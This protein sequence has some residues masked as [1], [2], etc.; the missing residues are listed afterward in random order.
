MAGRFSADVIFFLDS[1]GSMKPCFKALRDNIQSFVGPLDGG[2]QGSWDLRLDFLSHRAGEQGRCGIHDFGTV[3]LED[4]NRIIKSLYGQQEESK[5]FFTSEVD[6]F[7]RSLMNLKAFGDEANFVALDTCLDFPWRESST[8]HRVV[9]LLTDEPLET[10]VCVEQ[11]KELI[12]ALIEKLHALS[13]KLFLVGPESWAYDHLCAADRSEYVVVDEG[14]AGLT[15]VDL[16]RVLEA[17]AKS[18]SVSILQV[19]A[20]ANPVKRGLFDQ[21]SWTEV[22]GNL[23]EK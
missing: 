6:S 13:V 11:Q 18:I 22:R 4:A 1:S 20:G 21:A 16:G 8:C 12:N 5:S 9:I 3:H 23:R 10:G 19:P 7:R 15:N 2:A 14:Q 17:M